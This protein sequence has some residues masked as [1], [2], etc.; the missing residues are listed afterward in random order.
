[1]L[2]WQDGKT[3]RIEGTKVLV[4]IKEMRLVDYLKHVEESLQ[5]AISYAGG[6]KLADL[7]AVEFQ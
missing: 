4:P 2:L 7:K 3:S 1:M 5:S 6:T